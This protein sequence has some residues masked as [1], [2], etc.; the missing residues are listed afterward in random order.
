[1]VHLKRSIIEVK[2]KSDCLAHALIIAISR[3]TKYPNFVAY[4]RGYKVHQKVQDLLQT[5]GISLQHGGGIPELQKFQDH[6]QSTESSFM[7]A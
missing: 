6:F 7:E 5:T 2:A 3:I 1:M 4:R